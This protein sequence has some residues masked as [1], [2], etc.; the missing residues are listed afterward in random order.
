MKAWKADSEQFYPLLSRGIR[1]DVLMSQLACCQQDWFL[2]RYRDMLDYD[3]M[4]EGHKDRL[5]DVIGSWRGDIQDIRS[6][7]AVVKG[8]EEEE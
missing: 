1:L 8:Q 6:V 3:I 4:V 2:E 7:L 5:V